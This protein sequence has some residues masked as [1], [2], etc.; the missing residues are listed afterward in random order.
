[1]VESSYQMCLDSQHQKPDRTVEHS[2]SE[3]Y[4]RSCLVTNTDD[5]DRINAHLR[6]QSELEQMGILKVVGINPEGLMTY[7][8]FGQ[9]YPK[10]E[11]EQ[12]RGCIRDMI[13]FINSR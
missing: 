10:T 4:Y 3:E 12:L 13:E 7:M 9:M 2:D 6:A 5:F 11:T 1:M 8:I